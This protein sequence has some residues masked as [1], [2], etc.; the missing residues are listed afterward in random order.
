M[1]CPARSA[2]RCAV[3]VPGRDLF[4]AGR[5]AHPPY[6]GVDRPTIALRERGQFCELTPRRVTQIRP[7]IVCAFADGQALSGT[8]SRFCS[9][10]DMARPRIPHPTP[11][12]LMMLRVIWDSGD[13]TVREVHNALKAE[14]RAG[15]NSTLKIMQIMEDKGYVARRQPT[16]RPT[17]Y[18]ARLSEKAAK[19]RVLREI[20]KNLFAGSV[21]DLAK[22]A[23]MMKR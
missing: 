9:N 13:A 5:P 2:M 16:Q 15:Y 10:S 3:D 21:S 4:P 22:F 19:A 11:A 6:I 23:A 20:A 7:V 14:R 1:V 17:R 18:L 8:N 12:E